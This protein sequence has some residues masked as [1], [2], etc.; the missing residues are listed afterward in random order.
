MEASTP[1]WGVRVRH[2]LCLFPSPPNRNYV[3]IHIPLKYK[4][5]YKNIF[6]IKSIFRFIHPFERY[7][8]GTLILTGWLCSSEIDVDLAILS[9]VTSF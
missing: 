1:L 5:K 8:I 6:G 4:L 3:Y 9:H 2:G 7:R